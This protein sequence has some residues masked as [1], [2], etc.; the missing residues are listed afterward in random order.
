MSRTMND[1]KESF[2]IMKAITTRKR[3]YVMPYVC[4]VCCLKTHIINLLFNL[5]RL[6]ITENIRAQ[7]CMYGS[8]PTGSVRTVK[9]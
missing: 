8:H 5:D 6:V 3:L 1:L 9:G 4:K 7:S 2:T